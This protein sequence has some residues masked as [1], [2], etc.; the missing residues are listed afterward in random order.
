[1]E[2]QKDFTG[3]W[4][5]RHIL[6]S[7][8]LKPVDRL[9]YAEIACFVECWHTNTKLAERT[10]TS[11]PTVTRSMSRLIE[12]GYVELVSFNGRNRV[13]K[14]LAD[15]PPNQND[16][17][18]SSKRLG[19]PIKMSRQPSQNDTLDNKKITIRKQEVSTAKADNE[20][21]KLYYQYLKKYSIPVLNHTVLKAKIAELEK[22]RGTEWCVRYLTFMLEHYEFADFRYKPEIN[23]A[24]DLFRKSKGIETA[25]N[26]QLQLGKVY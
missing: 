15:T 21:S 17:A 25:M 14:A 8:E 3:V 11:E 20:V 1:M 24:L 9:I 7:A 4:I 23:D 12:L 10:G 26:K 13:V 18:D 16:E 19:S 22:L 6:E 5:P 2:Q